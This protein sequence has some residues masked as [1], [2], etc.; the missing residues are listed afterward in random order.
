MWIKAYLS[1]LLLCFVFIDFHF[2]TATRC[3]RTPEGI[4][5]SRSPAD[6]RFKLRI[7]GDPDRYIPEE[8]YTSKLYLLTPLLCTVVTFNTFFLSVSLEGILRASN[9]LTHKFSGFFVTAEKDAADSRTPPPK[10]ENDSAV[11][12]FHIAMNAIS[13]LSDKCQN[14]VTHTSSYPKSDVPVMTMAFA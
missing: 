1:R 2:S 13:K 6:G 14:L 7:L 12:T 3:D 10:N 5:A 4:A 8:N 11:G 9:G